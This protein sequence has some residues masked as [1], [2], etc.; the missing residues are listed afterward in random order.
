[1]VRL[2]AGS[3]H[4][5]D[6]ISQCEQ[7]AKERGVAER[8]TPWQLVFRK[9]MFAPWQGLSAPDPVATNLIYRQVSRGIKLGEYRCSQ[10]K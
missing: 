10:V 5:M 1:M 4:I 6:A 7:D 9:E 8:D 3:Y 2:E